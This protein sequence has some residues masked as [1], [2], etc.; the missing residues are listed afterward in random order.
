M[1]VSYAGPGWSSYY[2]EE[3]SCAGSAWSSYCFTRILRRTRL[4]PVV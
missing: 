4:L 2:D 3:V 1:E